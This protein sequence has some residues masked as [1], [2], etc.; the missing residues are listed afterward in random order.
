[1]PSR[2][3]NISYKEK[4]RYIPV[5]AFSGVQVVATTFQ[6]S[7]G[8]GNPVFEEISTLGYCAP[9]FAALN[10]AVQHI[11]PIPSEIDTKEAVEIR[12][13]WL[14]QNTGASKTVTW[15]IL[16]DEFA[17]GDALAVPTTAL[18]TAL[19]ADTDDTSAYGINLTDWGKISKNTLTAGN[20]WGFVISL[21]ASDLVPGTDK[22]YLL[23]M[24]IRYTPSLTVDKL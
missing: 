5:Q 22:H 20:L 23:G 1:M 24:E 9:D 21:S 16:Y 18:D 14:S 3:R 19:V 7:A 12:L 8:A 11:E 6:Q 15:K 4:T 2:D 13:K 17:E 10:D